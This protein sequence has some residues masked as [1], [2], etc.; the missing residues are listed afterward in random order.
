[1]NDITA[2]DE[3]VAHGR[4]QICLPNTVISIGERAYENCIN[5]QHM[6]LPTSLQTIKD[7]AFEDMYKLQELVIPST[8]TSIG[9]NIFN[10]CRAL[11]TL[12]VPFVGSVNYSTQA[13]ELTLFGYIFGTESERVQGNLALYERLLAVTN[14]L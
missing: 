7:R 3:D 4:E 9:V 10:G 14:C 11:N 1:M 13:S 12:T 5:L 2:Q 6:V 8:V